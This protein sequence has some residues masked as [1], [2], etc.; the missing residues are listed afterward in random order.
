LKV[1][2]YAKEDASRALELRRSLPKSKKFGLSPEEARMKGVNSGVSRARQII[3][4]DY[5]DW[6]NKSD[7]DSL[8]SMKSF[9]DRFKN[10]YTDKCEGNMMLWGG[11]WFLRNDVIPFVKKNKR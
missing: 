7:R 11:R 1:P 9:Y 2:D 5:Y 8:I 10:C 6:N 3:R 4:K